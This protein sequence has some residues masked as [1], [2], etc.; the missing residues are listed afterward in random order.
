MKRRWIVALALIVANAV[1]LSADV[2]LEI[3]GSCFVVTGQ[4]AFTDEVMFHAMLCDSDDSEFGF[5]AICFEGQD[6]PTHTVL[7]SVDSVFL[8]DGSK[9]AIKYRFDKEPPFIGEGVFSA[10]PANNLGLLHSRTR[11]DEVLDGVAAAESLVFQLDGETRWFH[12]DDTDGEAAVAELRS[13]C[14]PG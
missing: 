12:F 11:F 6:I 1:A 5:G 9:V 4:D 7:F 2:D 10:S 14:S 8:I 13:R 3:F